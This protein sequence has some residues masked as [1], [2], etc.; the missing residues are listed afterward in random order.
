MASKFAKRPF[1]K[2]RLLI[3]ISVKVKDIDGNIIEIPYSELA[4]EIHWNQFC[5]VW[6][7]KI[8]PIIRDTG[9]IELLN[10]L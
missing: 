6:N 2:S 5:F 3:M 1:D 7:D 10:K 8:M 4:K 9:I